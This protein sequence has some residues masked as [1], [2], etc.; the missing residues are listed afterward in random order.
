MKI[1]SLIIGLLIGS[2]F[3]IALTTFIGDLSGYTGISV[4][5]SFNATYTK[6]NETLNLTNNATDTFLR[7]STDSSFGAAVLQVKSFPIFTLVLNSFDIFMS[8]ITDLTNTLNLP[9]WFL[10]VVAGIM[11]VLILFTILGAIFYRDL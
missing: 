7:A 1:S 11:G 6:I 9:S 4:D 3:I 5:T 10:P 2:A 8:M